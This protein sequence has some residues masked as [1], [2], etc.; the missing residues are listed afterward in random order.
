MAEAVRL[1]S[2][3]YVNIKTGRVGG[4]TNAVKIHDICKNAGIPCWVGGN[5]ES[6]V[7]SGI[8]VE[9]AT[10]PNFKYPADIFPTKVQYAE[11]LSAPEIALAEPGK[12][13]VSHVPGIPYEPRPEMLQRH[14]ISK[15]FV[16]K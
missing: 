3:R 1:G 16:T 9:L 14:A 12:I 5:L 13:A 6:A 10:L 4:L 15:A 11:D 8:S 2:C 7:G